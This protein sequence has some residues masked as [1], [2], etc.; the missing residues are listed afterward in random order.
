MLRAAQVE[1]PAD[2]FQLQQKV[3]KL[4]AVE[5]AAINFF[6]LREDLKS[7]LDILQEIKF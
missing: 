6:L 2:I 7:V 4:K 3:K 1:L 5:S